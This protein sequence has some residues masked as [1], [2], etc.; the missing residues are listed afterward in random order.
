MSYWNKYV[1]KTR[2]IADISKEGRVKMISICFALATV[3][4]GN[5]IPTFYFR[6]L[7]PL[8]I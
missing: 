5:Q 3:L 2:N 7:F 8:Q 6:K 4:F 1:V